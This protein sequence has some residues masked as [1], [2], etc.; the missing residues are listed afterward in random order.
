M[1]KAI[2][3]PIILICTVRIFNYGIYT[4]R[5]NNKT[6][7]VGLFI[8]TALTSLSFVYFLLK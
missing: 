7:G 6:G 2:T 4:V 5:D 1:E 3:L 8:L